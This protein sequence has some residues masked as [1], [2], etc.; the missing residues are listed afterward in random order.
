LSQMANATGQPGQA[1]PE[2]GIETFD[3]GRVDHAILLAE[4]Q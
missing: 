2:G 3:V 4:A 1:L